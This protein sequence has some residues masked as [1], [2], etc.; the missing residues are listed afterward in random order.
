MVPVIL[1]EIQLLYWREDKEI[2][3]DKKK[4]RERLKNSWNK[5][6]YSYPDM[7]VLWE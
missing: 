4:P 6:K 3:D 1:R 7:M 2:I 5:K